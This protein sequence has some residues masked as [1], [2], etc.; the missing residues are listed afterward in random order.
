MNAWKKEKFTGPKI[1]TMGPGLAE[2]PVFIRAERAADFEKIFPPLPTDQ[3]GEDQSW[4]RSE[5]TLLPCGGRFFV[6][7]QMFPAPSVGT[8]VVV[9]FEDATE[10]AAAGK[11]ALL[12]DGIELEVGE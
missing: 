11:S 6:S 7:G 1:V 2:I 4:N 9:R 8:D 3:R 5:R 12:G 10:I